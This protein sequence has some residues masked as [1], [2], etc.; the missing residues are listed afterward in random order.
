M[1][2]NT[3]STT[4]EATRLEPGYRPGERM[5]HGRP[6]VFNQD[7]L[8]AYLADCT[9]ADGVPANL[10]ALTYGELTALVGAY[11]SAW[12]RRARD[13]EVQ[14]FGAAVCGE[15]ATRPEHVAVYGKAA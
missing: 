8:N 15:R 2:L 5:L 11:L 9:V 1:P 6:Y 4:K 10:A 13:P 12:S 3:A 14:A 7:L